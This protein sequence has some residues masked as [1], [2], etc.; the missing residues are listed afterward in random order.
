MK[1]Q[2]IAILNLLISAFFMGCA[3]DKINLVHVKET[4]VFSDPKAVFYSNDSLNES[5]AKTLLRHDIKLPSKI[6]VAIIRLQPKSDENDYAEYKINRDPVAHAKNETSTYLLDLLKDDSFDKHQIT[7]VFVPESLIPAKANLDSI[8][9][10]GMT[11]QAELILVVDSRNDRILNKQIV[12]SDAV[13]MTSSADTYLIDTKSGA[14]VNANSYT[15][16]SFAKKDQKEFDI[17]QTLDR[18]RAESEKKIYKNLAA[19]I[20]DTLETVK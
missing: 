18:A 14:I 15:K 12:K 20:K 19:D 2:N 16:E 5:S 7:P 6:K 8:R 1:L 11:M 10:L 13:L 4:N 3:S 9:K 17:Y